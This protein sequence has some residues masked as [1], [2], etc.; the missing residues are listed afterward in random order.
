MSDQYELLPDDEKEIQETR[1]ILGK[2]A[3]GMTDEDIK[4][5]ITCIDYLVQTWMDEYERTIF[6]GKTLNEF[7]NKL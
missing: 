1:K 4:H 7:I 5:Q 6:D 2:C 3:E